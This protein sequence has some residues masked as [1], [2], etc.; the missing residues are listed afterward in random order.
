MPVTGA[1]HSAAGIS[2]RTLLPYTTTFGVNDDITLSKGT[3][4]LLSADRYALGRMVGG[5]G[6][7]RRHPFFFLAATY[8]HVGLFLGNVCTARQANP[9]PLNLN[10]KFLGCVRTPGK[11]L[12]S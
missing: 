7:V 5:A 2:T 10:Q 4:S 1:F 8:G 3:T 12:R 6:M 11:S 9:N